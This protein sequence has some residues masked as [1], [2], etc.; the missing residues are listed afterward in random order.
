MFNLRI[1]FIGRGLVFLFAAVVFAVGV[2]MPSPT[3]NIQVERLADARAERE[4]LTARVMTVLKDYRTGLAFSEERKLAQVIVDESRTYGMDPLLVLALIKTE[5]T[6]YNW[7]KSFKGA[8]GLMQ[9]LPT[10]GEALAR[11]LDLEW[12][13]EETLL[14]PF[15]NVKLGIHYLS[16]LKD[17]FKDDTGFIAA[18]NTGPTRLAYRRRL[19]QNPGRWYADRVLANYENM[20]ETTRYD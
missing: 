13:G 11:E 1:K 8:V 16:K 7:S 4:E 20:K 2:L 18:Y 5:S 9:I 6:F 15:V 3:A 12:A 14:N 19:G 17:R 10:T